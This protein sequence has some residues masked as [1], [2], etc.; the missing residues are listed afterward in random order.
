MTGRVHTRLSPFRRADW[1][2][3]ARGFPVWG[4]VALGL[5][6]F[7][8]LGCGYRPVYS[9]A[10]AQCLHVQSGRPMVPDA[11]VISSA[12]EGA[13]ASLAR[14]TCL[15]SGD[16]FP[17]LVV[18]VLRI[19]ELGAGIEAQGKEPRAT[20]SRVAVL[21]RGRIETKVEGAVVRDTGNLRRSETYGNSTDPRLD[22]QLWHAAARAAAWE[23]GAAIGRAAVGVPEPDMEPL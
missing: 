5:T 21:G 18:D 22:G 16:G 2:L 20:A 23:L 13:R 6:A 15:A 17:R 11:A 14:E 9:A 10:P 12:L 4:R 7:G 8:L 3:L 1:V 19:D